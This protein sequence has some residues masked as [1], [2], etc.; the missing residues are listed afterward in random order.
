LLEVTLL[1]SCA[2]RGLEVCVPLAVAFEE[3]GEGAREATGDGHEEPPAVADRG[4]AAGGD[5]DLD[6]DEDEDEDGGGV[7]MRS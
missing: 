7:C 6:W 3:S 5:L 2:S 4:G 1:S